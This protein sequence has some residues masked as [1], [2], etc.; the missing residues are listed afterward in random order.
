MVK[1]EVIIAAGGRGKRL[2]LNTPKAF[3]KIKGKPLIYYTL[4]KF[5]EHPWVER[6]V[7]IVPVAKVKEAQRI[8]TS[9]KFTKVK[10]V[11]SGGKKRADSV[12]EGLKLL[13]KNSKYILIHDGA[14]PL[15]SRTLITEI[16]TA[17]QRHPLVVPAL[18]I[19]D[20]IKC[21]NR[22]RV[23]SLNRE[24]L[25]QIQTPQGLKKRYALEAYQ[26]Y[27]KYKY[28][29]DDSQLLENKIKPKLVEGEPLNLKITTPKDLV[30]FKRLINLREFKNL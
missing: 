29:Y 22:E 19:K 13:D 2:K 3:V 8:V 27:K 1:A 18:K 5:Q 14:R 17:L 21:I 30:I 7:L 10:A 25:Y 20:A 28:L 26:N 4:K 24:G 12:Y 16:I 23:V 9:Y 6:I 11:S 15:V